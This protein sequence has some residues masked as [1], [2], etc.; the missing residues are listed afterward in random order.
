MEGIFM[1][2][3]FIGSF[4]ILLGMGLGACKKET[5]R[6]RV[7]EKNNVEK[8]T[9]A[10]T[11]KTEEKKRKPFVLAKKDFE[12]IPNNRDPFKSHIDK[13]RSSS[14]DIRCADTQRNVFFKQ[15]A[16]DEL[17]LIAIVSGQTRA[18]AMFRDP[19][20]QSVT[21]KR[22]TYL[23]NS[24]GKIKEIYPDRVV[25]EVIGRYEGKNKRA[26]RVIRLHKT[27]S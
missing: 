17:S 2:R 20:G 13:N 15:Y 27:S 18:Q 24:C 1:N 26:D 8:Q 21:L 9:I 12:D 3:M 6:Q 23:S 10:S 11:P 19:K 14:K 22:G 16:L 25:I 4:V 5:Q 7:K